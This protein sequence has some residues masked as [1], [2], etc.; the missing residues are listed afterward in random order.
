MHF[1]NFLK[2]S[3]FLATAAVQVTAVDH[4]VT[5]GGSAGNIFTPEFVTAQPGDTVIFTFRQ[6]NHTVTQS[7]F[8]TPCQR[9]DQG[10]DSGFVPVPPE[11]TDG[12]FTAAQ[13][14]VRDDQPIWAYCGQANH[15][16]QGMVFAVNPGDRFAAFKAAAMATGGTPPASSSLS[17]PPPLSTTTPVVINPPPTST[18]TTGTDHRV[19]V[20]GPGR[21]LFDPTN[22]V[23]QP[24][25][26]VTF[27]FRQKN[28]T[29]TQSTFNDPCRPM[30]GGFDTGYQPVADG[31]T[32]FPTQTIPVNGTQPVWVY[33]AQGNHCVSGMVFAINPETNGPNTFE[34]FR[35]RAMGGS[36][37]SVLPSGGTPTSTG[38]GAPA[39]TTTDVGAAGRVNVQSIAGLSVILFATSFFLL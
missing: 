27:E 1:S 38:V 36:S 39:P 7:T 37:S 16:Q 35:A 2:F 4:N 25:D 20:G 18:P 28:H 13:L 14:V 34:A 26:T 11:N 32:N 12:P 24:G 5:V 29:A 10:F 6:K 19:V 30:A 23:A 21:L 17:P 8:A 9:L 3:A 31:V 15:C 33:C 22:I